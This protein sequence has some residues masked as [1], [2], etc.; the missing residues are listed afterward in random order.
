MPPNR[1]R[2]IDRHLL[3]AQRAEGAADGELLAAAGGEGLVQAGAVGF[4]LRGF[5]LCGA[6][7]GHQAPCLAIF[8]V[9]RFASA[10]GIEAQ[11]LA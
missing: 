10:V 2:Q 9:E 4:D 6:R 11:V 8:F 5:D 3:R 1:E 7:T